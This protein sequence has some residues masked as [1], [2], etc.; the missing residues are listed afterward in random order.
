MVTVNRICPSRLNR[1]AADIA[2]EGN[3]ARND[4]GI[5][6]DQKTEG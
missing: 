2:L 5:K 4:P 6:D 3:R 1:S